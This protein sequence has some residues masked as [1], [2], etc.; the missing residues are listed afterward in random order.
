MSEFVHLHLHTEFSLLDGACRIDE[1]LDQVQKLKM[2]AV[3]VTE[4]GNMFS[5]VVFHDHARARGV[6]PILGCEVYVAPGQ[7][8]PEGRAAGRE[9]QPPGAA[10][11]D[12]PGLAQSDQAGVGRL[13]RRLLPQAAHRQ[14]P[15]RA[16]RGRPDRLEQLP[17][18]RSPGTAVRLAGCRRACVGGNLPRHPRPEQLLSRDAV[19]RHRGS[20]GREPRARAH[21]EGSR[22]AAHLHERRALPAITATTCRTTSCCASAR[23]RR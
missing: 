3:A 4:H 22:A 18:G 19:A 11:G 6:K 23:E 17:Q 20:E 5:A 1:L 9:L 15:A 14:G 21:R 16:A 2:P 7:P 13:H 8:A 12:A 10:R